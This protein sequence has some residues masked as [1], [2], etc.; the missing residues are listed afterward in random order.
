MSRVMLAGTA[1]FVYGCIGLAYNVIKV[2][3]VLVLYVIS[4]GVD[5]VEGEDE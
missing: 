4:R 5:M 1:L 3:C 2:A